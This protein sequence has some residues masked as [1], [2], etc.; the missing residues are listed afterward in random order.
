MKSQMT[1]APFAGLPR[2]TS[3]RLSYVL[4]KRAGLL[5]AIEASEKTFTLSTSNAKYLVNADIIAAFSPTLASQ[6]Y[7]DPP[8]LTV[9]LTVPDPNGAIA[10]LAI[11]LN[12]G[13][14]VVTPSERLIIRQA[15]LQLR[16]NDYCF[17][18]GVLSRPRHNI[19]AQGPRRDP[20]AEVAMISL[21]LLLAKIPK[22]FRLEVRGQ[23]YLVNSLGILTSTVLSSAVKD[24]TYSYDYSGDESAILSVCNFFNGIDAELV[25]D[26]RDD[27]L[28]ICDDLGISSLKS[29]ILDYEARAASIHAVFSDPASPVS[30]AMRLQESLFSISP[31]TVASLAG[32][33]E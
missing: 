12:G 18:P 11:L 24:Q 30:R 3:P 10:K 31:E 2:E 33:I 22:T 21:S 8:N 14:T 19:D 26:R 1:D 25:L 27:V 6:I 28:Q 29:A 15:V 16:L 17:P 32:D 5:S 23:T 4:N 13:C 7:A 9:D 20:N